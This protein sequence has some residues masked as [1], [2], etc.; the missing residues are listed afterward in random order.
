MKNLFLRC[1]AF[2]FA[3]AACG[4]GSSQTTGTLQNVSGVRRAPDSYLPRDAFLLFHAEVDAIR[5]SPYQAALDRLLE[6]GKQAEAQDAEAQRL[7]GLGESAFAGLSEV[8]I[9]AAQPATPDAEPEG[10]VLFRHRGGGEVA[11]WLAAAFP[12]MTESTLAGHR[13]FQNGEVRVTA[14]D[15]GWWLWAADEALFTQTL[16]GA[17]TAAVAEQPLVREYAESL[18]LT[19]SALWFAVRGNGSNFDPGGSNTPAWM[20]DLTAAAGS[21]DLSDTTRID[22]R[23]IFAADHGAMFVA[24]YLNTALN[25]M[26]SS[27]GV[28]MFGAG[29]L[30][31]AITVRAQGSVA[32]VHFSAASTEITGLIGRLFALIE[33]GLTS[34]TSALPEATP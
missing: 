16:L 20:R 4:G 1:I 15:D 12:E 24:E 17:N 11:T 28:L 14:L 2:A 27:P 31:E 23:G 9:A 8:W 26:R 32:S 25:E 18:G 10:L 3:L 21:A 5:R 22:L 13:V 34:P 6:F 7:L 29:P 33:M 19:S 30:L